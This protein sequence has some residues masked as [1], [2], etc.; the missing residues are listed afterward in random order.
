M[1]SMV[2]IL[3]PA[4]NAERWVGDTIRSALNQAWPNKEIIVIDDGSTDETL[5][6]ARTFESKSVRVVTQP[7]Q[8]AATARNKAFSLSGGEYIQWLDADD[9][10]AQ[11]K[12]SKQMKVAARSGSRHTLLSSAWGCFRYRPG[13]ARFLRTALWCDLDPI[14]WLTRKWEENLHMQTATWLVSRELTEAAGPWDSRLLNNDDGEYFCRVLRA[15]NGVRFV[16]DAKVFYRD[17]GPSSLSYVGQS[18][19]KIEA[20]FL[21]MQL[22]INSLRSMSDTKRVRAACLRHLENCLIYFYPQRPDIVAQLQQ[23]AADLGGE[24]RIPPRWSWK[25][26]WI[27]KLFGFTAAKHTQS[28]YNWAKSFVLRT[29]DRTLYSVDWRGRFAS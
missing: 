5:A 24:L 10:L 16:R 26:L 1:K 28:Y 19:R 14:E 3:I 18:N 6:V 12:I 13:K 4:Y 17:A 7:N 9:L 27:E 22:Q 21:G 15:S 11:D 8:G 29:W 25:Y 2:S 23:L 20:H